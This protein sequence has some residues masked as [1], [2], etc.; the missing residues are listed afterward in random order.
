VCR[1]FSELHFPQNLVVGL[2][3]TRW[4]QQCT[5]RL[6]VPVDRREDN[7]AQPSPR[8]GT[9][10]TSM[11]ID[12]PQ[13]GAYSGRHRFIAVDGPGRRILRYRPAWRFRSSGYASPMPVLS[14]TVEVSSKPPRSWPSSPTSSGTRNGATGSTACWV[15]ARYDD[16]RPPA[17]PGRR[18][19]G[20]EGTYIQAGVLPA[21]TRFRP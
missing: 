11:S 19:Q 17:A 2:A 21:R 13:A 1:Y 7:S 14:K 18:Y 15:L 5:Y 4:A 8:W 6:G 9:G 16:G 20:F 12:Q 10:C 3:V